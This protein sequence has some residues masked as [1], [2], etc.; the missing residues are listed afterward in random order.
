MGNFKIREFRRAKDIRQGDFATILGL[1]QSNLSRVETNGIDLTE[2]QL[3]MLRQEY[4]RETVDAYITDSAEQIKVG[5]I[6]PFKGGNLALLDLLSVV[7]KQNETICQQ[8]DMQN[9]IQIQLTAI[10]T[11]LVTLLEKLSI[12]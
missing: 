6:P 4:G 8:I 11:S 5:E 9:Q 10:S 12:K 3:D 2:K 1:S 7:K